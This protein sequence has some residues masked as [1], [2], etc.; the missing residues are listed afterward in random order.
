VLRVHEFAYFLSHSVAERRLV[1]SIV[2]VFA[3][4]ALTLAVVGVYGLFAYA[5][6]SRTRELGLRIALG[7]SRARV[8]WLTVRQGLLLGSLGV[9]V[10]TAGTFAGQRLIETQLYEVRPTD[11]ATFS[12]VAVTVLATALLASYVPARRAARIDPTTALRVE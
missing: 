11:P 2:T 12:A 1:T 6:V 5:V 4:L 9:V 10:G 3:G 7:A 8:I